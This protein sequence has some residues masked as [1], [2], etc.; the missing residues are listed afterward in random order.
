MDPRERRI[1]PR[2]TLQVDV[3]FRLLTEGTSHRGSSQNISRGGVCLISHYPLK[4]QDVLQLE[5]G[6]PGGLKPIQVSGRVVW[7]KEFVIGDEAQ[8]KRFDVGVEFM[9]V[10]DTTLGIIS[11]YL[12]TLKQE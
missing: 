1:F 10:N 6:L 8:G 9:E 2:F 7:V 3:T 11:N 12:F 5:I 4:D